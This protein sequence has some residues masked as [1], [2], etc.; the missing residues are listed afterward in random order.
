M[1]ETREY[2]ALTQSQKKPENENRLRGFAIHLAVYFMTML[3]I[4]PL[5]FW[6][7]PNLEWFVLPL[8]GWGSALSLHVAYVMGLFEKPVREKIKD[9]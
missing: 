6:L 8:V 7:T 1:E 5:D 3:I 4:V 9:R 2:T